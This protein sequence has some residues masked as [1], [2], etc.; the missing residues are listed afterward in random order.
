MKGRT[1]CPKCRSEESEA[2]LKAEAEEKKKELAA[3]IR[4]AEC[5]K[6]FAQKV[7]DDGVRH[8][9]PK[10]C[11]RICRR[12]ACHRASE[13]RRR[14]LVKTAGTYSWQGIY[15]KTDGKCWI[16]GEMVDESD[17]KVVG[18]SFVAGPRYPSVDHI[19]PLSK[20]GTS[21]PG[22]ML[23]AHCLCNSLRGSG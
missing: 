23:L 21:E 9:T 3:P 16:C 14:A 12:R 5:G 10:Y 1:W 15:E 7:G 2:A 13:H 8:K 6:E 17:F 19:V 22:N 20:G 18:G 4:C 11:S